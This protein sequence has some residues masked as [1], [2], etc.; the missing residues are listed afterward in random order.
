MS[1][2]HPAFNPYMYSFPFPYPPH[3]FMNPMMPHQARNMSVPNMG[4]SMPPKKAFPAVPYGYPPYPMMYPPSPYPFFPF[5]EPKTP[6]RDV[7]YLRVADMS[8]E[9]F[10]SIPESKKVKGG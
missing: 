6:A 1:N 5:Y 7:E 9:S 4:E 10:C 2:Q 3:P 8:K